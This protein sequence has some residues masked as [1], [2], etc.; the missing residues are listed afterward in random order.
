[1]ENRCVLALMAHPDDAEILCAGT[2]IRLAE[3]GWSVHVAT[4]TPGDCGSMTQERWQISAARTAE[5]T[6]AAAT[7]GAAYHCLD[8]GDGLVVYDKPTLQKCFDLFRRVV[9]SLVLTHAP[10][11]YMMDH[12]IVSKLARGASFM[13]GCPN[14]SDVPRHPHARVPYL[15]FCDPVA[16]TE[17]PGLRVEPTTLVDISTQLDAK[18]AMLACHGSQREW[19]R[20]HHG[21][22]EY[23]DA[24]RRHAAARGRDAGVAAAEAFVQHRVHAYPSDDLLAGTF[25]LR[26]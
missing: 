14:C 21:V 24:M 20:A 1:M 4:L 7:I 2:L 11:D 5:A 10:S 26:P 9:P 23:V 19:L 22:D 17:T 16:A 18:A 15:Y 6:R 12:E 13:Y 3:L 25:P 8:E